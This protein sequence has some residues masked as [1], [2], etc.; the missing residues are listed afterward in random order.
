MAFF[1]DSASNTRE[2]TAPAP[3]PVVR[4]T[5]APEPAEPIRRAPERAAAPTSAPARA[6]AKESFISAELTLEGKIEGAGSVRIAGRF[7]GDVNVQGNLTIDRG[8]QV[9]GQVKARHVVIEGALE[10]N[11]TG[12]E[13]VELRESGVL[14]GDVKAGQFTVAAGSKM[15]GQVEFGWED[16]AK[17]AAA[18]AAA[19]VAG[20]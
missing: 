6:E 5:A 12:A 9:S 20:G 8:A 19:R 16:T 1:K 4:P 17:G 3:E 14:T 13:R 18:P 2:T 7:K 11:V 10:G 15:R